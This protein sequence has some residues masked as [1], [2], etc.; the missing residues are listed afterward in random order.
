LLFHPV[1]TKTKEQGQKLQ[2]FLQKEFRSF[3][4]ITKNKKHMDGVWVPKVSEFDLKGS[5]GFDCKIWLEEDERVYIYAVLKWMAQLDCADKKKS[6][7]FVK[8]QHECDLSWLKKYEG[9]IG[10]YLYDGGPCLL[11]RL[12]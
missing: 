10:Y 9:W 5:A 3:S 1:K 11:S 12:N 6:E 4:E 2:K 7:F 8:K